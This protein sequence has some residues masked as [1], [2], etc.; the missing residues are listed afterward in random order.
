MKR[1]KFSLSHYKLASCMMGKLVPICWYETLPG[2]TIQQSTSMLVRMSP[3]LAPLMHPVKVRIHSWFIPNRLL[4]EDWEDFITGGSD[5]TYTADPPYK[6]MDGQLYQSTMDDYLGVPIDDYTSNNLAV[7]AL[8]YRAY[9]MIW[10]EH[11]RDQDLQ[12]ERNISLASGE[13]N[14]TSKVLQHVSWE[15]DYFTTARPWETKGDD[16]MISLGDDA[17]VMGIGKLDASYTDGPSTLRFSDGSTES[18]AYA[19]IHSTATA[20]HVGIKESD[21]HAGFPGIY[22]DLSQTSGI[23]VNDLREALAIQRYQEARANY[24]SRYVEYLRYLGV[25]PSDGRLQNPEYLGG[26]SQI[27]QFSEVLQTSTGGDNGV[28]DMA[29]HGIAALRTNRF[30]RFFEEHGIVMTMM[31][32]VP[33]AIY[34]QQMH[35]KWFRQTKEDYFQKELQFIGE[36]GIENREIFPNQADQEEIFGYQHRYDEY[37]MENSGIS[38]DFR[39][40]YDHWH[41]ARNLASA[42]ALNADFI[43]CNPSDR[44]FA[45]QSND[46]CLVMAQHSI[47]ARRMLSK[48]AKNKTF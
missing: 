36:Q 10:N 47:Q 16:V 48:F 14:T 11:Y 28:G 3:L 2:D 15:K 1:N 4:W 43:E 41:L 40:N 33:K 24:G 18:T 9:N 21:D 29:G 35:K 38:G 34:M 31:S 44:C 22:A 42:P 32:V 27:V 8:P 30:R 23:S 26:G 46:T 5:G 20:G 25:R 37:R 17:P 19:R 7:S 39:G 45:D 13:D 12:S 6:T